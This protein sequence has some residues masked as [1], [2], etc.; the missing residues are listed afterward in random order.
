[1]SCTIHGV[2]QP[3][4]PETPLPERDYE[5]TQVDNAGT[6]IIM[7]T[8]P[9]SAPGPLQ[10]I[11]RLRRFIWFSTSNSADR[12]RVQL[13]D[14]E[15]TQET[16]PFAITDQYWYYYRVSGTSNGGKAWTV[17]AYRSLSGTTSNRHRVLHFTANNGPFEVGAI[18][19]S[20]QNDVIGLLKVYNGNVSNRDVEAVVQTKGVIHTRTFGI[21]SNLARGASVVLDGSNLESVI[22]SVMVTTQQSFTWFYSDN[23]G[24]SYVQVL[25]ETTSQP[26][27]PWHTLVGRD[28][29]VGTRDTANRIWKKPFGQPLVS[30]GSP[31]NPYARIINAQG[32]TGGYLI[33]SYSQP[34]NDGNPPE[35]RVAALN[36]NADCGDQNLVQ[37]MTAAAL[38]SQLS[39]FVTRRGRTLFRDFPI[40]MREASERPQ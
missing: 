28:V 40:K 30:M 6:S 1:M 26:V 22:V 5:A 15:S 35:T 14:N 10:F 20:A 24:A 33:L 16:F 3:L 37:N 12:I 2:L 21:R 11:A 13:S 8:L 38:S 25:A 23:G 27:F 34:G 17:H 39:C 7:S 31:L 4:T 18:T 36:M 32:S 9:G 29:Y 19:V